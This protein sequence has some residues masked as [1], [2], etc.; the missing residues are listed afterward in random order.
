MFMPPVEAMYAY[1]KEN[2]PG[3]F[4][5]LYKRLLVGSALGAVALL[6]IMAACL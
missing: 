2:G 4:I 6:I 5:R 3:S 1:E